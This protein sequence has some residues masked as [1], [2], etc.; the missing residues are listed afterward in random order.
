MWHHRKVLRC[1]VLLPLQSFRTPAYGMGSRFLSQILLTAGLGL[2]QGAWGAGFK[3]IPAVRVPPLRKPSMS[4]LPESAICQ[5]PTSTNDHKSTMRVDLRVINKV[6]WASG[7]TNAESVNIRAGLPFDI[8]SYKL[9]LASYL[10]K[11][12]VMCWCSCWPSTPLKGVQ[13]AEQRWGTLCLSEGRTGR[14][15]L[16]ILRYSQELI[17]WAKFL[18]LLISWKALR[19][20]MVTTVSH[21]QK[22]TSWDQQKLSGKI[23]AW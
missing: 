4:L 9:A 2:D 3:E 7:F 11:D 16:Q 18:Y 15:G 12:W 1:Y 8:V 13:G 14:T 22:E 5:V 6:Y 19:S 20:F 17:L 21:D 10:Y 23:C